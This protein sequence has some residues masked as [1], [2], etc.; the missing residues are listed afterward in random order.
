MK[1]LDA[2][3]ASAVKRSASRRLAEAS[4]FIPQSASSLPLAGLAI[5]RL[6]DFARVGPTNLG[7]QPASSGATRLVS[8]H[9]LADGIAVVTGIGQ[10]IAGLVGKCGDLL[11]DCLL[12]GAAG[13]IGGGRQRPRYA[14]FWCGDDD[15]EGV[16]LDPAIMLREAPGGVAINPPRQATATTQRRVPAPTPS[17]DEALVG[18]HAAGIGPARQDGFPPEFPTAY[19]G[20]VKNLHSYNIAPRGINLPCSLM[21]NDGQVDYVKNIIENILLKM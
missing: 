7:A 16:A 21:L 18:G 15:L 20:S 3:L 1:R 8:F 6:T 9:R 17:G 2:R 11:Q 10:D 4:P 5:V 12:L 14:L 13:R 19:E